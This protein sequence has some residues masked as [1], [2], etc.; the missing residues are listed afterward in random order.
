MY[1]LSKEDEGIG[2]MRLAYIIIAI[3]TYKSN[4]T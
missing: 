4:K 3:A 2:R 1:E